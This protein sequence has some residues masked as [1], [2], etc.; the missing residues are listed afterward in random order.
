MDPDL[1]RLCSIEGDHDL[2]AAE[3]E[4]VLGLKERTVRRMVIKG[5]I[6]AKR[7]D[8]GGDG[9]QRRIRISRQAVVNYLLKITTGDKTALL[10][11]IAAQCPQYLPAAQGLKSEPAPLPPN[12]VP[13]SE[14]TK[15]RH[16]KPLGDPYADHP[17]LFA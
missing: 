5:K 12:V 10:S 17:R 6:E 8:A 1:S 11:A 7:Y 15:P 16:K 2:T 3:V 14:G 4:H 9:N 13:I